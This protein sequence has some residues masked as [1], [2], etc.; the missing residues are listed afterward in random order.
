MLKEFFIADWLK[1]RLV[2]YALSHMIVSP[3][4]LLWFYVV[5]AGE[6]S[7]GRELLFLSGLAYASSGAFEVARKTRGPEE[8]RATVDSYSKR[9][10]TRG[11]SLLLGAILSVCLSATLLTLHSLDIALGGSWWVA[12]AAYLPIAGSLSA[13]ARAPSAEARK[14][15]EALTA[16]CLMLSH[17]VP[18]M[19]LLTERGLSWS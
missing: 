12:I 3:L 7:I 15:N 18:T 17:L 9:L 10:G 6:A 8:E 5:G 13:F 16:L 4:T 11:A 19:A 2:P 14:R 1:T